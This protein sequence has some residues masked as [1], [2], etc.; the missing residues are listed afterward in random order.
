M[1][2]RWRQAIL[3]THI[4]GVATVAGVDVQDVRPDATPVG[5]PTSWSG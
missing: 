4:P 3:V 2:T 5:T 1:D